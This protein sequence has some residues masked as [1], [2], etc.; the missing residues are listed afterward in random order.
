M[1]WPW[2]CQHSWVTGTMSGGERVKIC[3]LCGLSKYI[4]EAHWYGPWRAIVSTT[5]PCSCPRSTPTFTPDD[6]Q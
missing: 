4:C 3:S 5:E 2:S 1:R 6:P